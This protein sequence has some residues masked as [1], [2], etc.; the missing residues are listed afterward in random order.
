MPPVANAIKALEKKRRICL[1][2]GFT[3]VQIERLLKLAR[4][5]CWEFRDDGA[6]RKLPYG[7]KN[8]FLDA[9]SHPWRRGWEEHLGK[10]KL[11]VSNMG[12]LYQKEKGVDTRL[13]IA[14]CQAAAEPKLDWT[15]LVTN[16]ADYVPL[17][18]H[19]H[20]RNK[21]VYLLSLGDPKGQSRDLK[22]A[23]GSRYLINKAKLYNGLT[24]EP[25]PEPYW[26]NA[27]TDLAPALLLVLIQVGTTLGRRKGA[28]VS[29]KKGRIDV[30]N[31]L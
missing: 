18:E 13:V 14:G 27:G 4:V 17:V 10:R 29:A 22:N 31:M 23:V 2:Q 9:L 24:D 7:F 20:S 11:D 1:R 12:R 26:S 5:G 28:K 30:R 16:D 19:L 3:P 8:A 21:A 15:C 6:P 25:I